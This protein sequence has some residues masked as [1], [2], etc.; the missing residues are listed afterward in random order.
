MKNQNSKYKHV[1]NDY[2]IESVE[3]NY[4]WFICKI[5]R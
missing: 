1:L 4:V 5:K 2:D 3:I